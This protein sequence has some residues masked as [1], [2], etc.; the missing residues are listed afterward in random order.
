MT[1]NKRLASRF[2]VLLPAQVT[3]ANG[4]Y[5]VR[6][7]DISSIGC[8]FMT[9]KIIN[10]QTTVSIQFFFPEQVAV[11]ESRTEIRHIGCASIGSRIIRKFKSTEK[12]MHVYGV[13]FHSLMKEHCVGDIIAELES[14]K[15]DNRKA[16]QLEHVNE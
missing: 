10:L 12:D 3:I 1:K 2:R 14:V 13:E 15:R 9:P 6:V 8:R 7:V 16:S 4:S 11:G 5:M